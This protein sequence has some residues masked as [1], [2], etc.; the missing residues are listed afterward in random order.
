MDTNESNKQG[1][2][3]YSAEDR[4][5]LVEEFE[6]SG[7]T[8]AAFCREWNINPA[9]FGKWLRS[10][11]EEEAKVAFCEVAAET[12]AESSVEVRVCLPNRVEVAVPV[13][14]P[15]DLANVLREAAQCLD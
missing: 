6:S 7:L 2:F 15:G 12:A 10:E 4:K 5:G 9:T 11:R 13:R 1:R 3:S 14:S 8:Q